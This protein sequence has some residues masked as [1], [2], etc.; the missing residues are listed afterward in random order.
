M[1][2]RRPFLFSW[3]FALVA[4]A[5]SSA[6]YAGAPAK[7]SV[8]AGWSG[9]RGAPASTGVQPA[10]FRIAGVHVVGMSHYRPEDVIRLSG[11]QIGKPIALTDLTT[12][13]NAL[14]ATG[15][16]DSVKYSYTTQSGQINVTFEIVEATR[17]LV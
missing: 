8:V 6:A 13:A 5:V 16:F 4:W 15:M 1:N 7:S 3:P 12:S 17:R 2:T 11:L 9:T 14:A 10:Q